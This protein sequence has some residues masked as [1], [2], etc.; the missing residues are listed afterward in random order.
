MVEWV[1]YSALAEMFSSDSS[2]FTPW[3]RLVFNSGLLSQWWSRHQQKNLSPSTF[4]IPI[5][6]LGI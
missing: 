6:T 4:P 1:N 3:F 5:Q 2:Q